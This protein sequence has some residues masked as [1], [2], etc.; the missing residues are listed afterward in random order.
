M[1]ITWIGNIHKR[2]F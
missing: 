2:N 1:K